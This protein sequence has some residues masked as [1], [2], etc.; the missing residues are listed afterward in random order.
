MKMDKIGLIQIDGIMPNLALMKASSFYKEKGFDVHFIDL[1]TLNI[2]NWLASKVF[3]GGSGY[4]LKENLPNEI[5]EITPDYEG[6]NLDY[7]IGFTSRGCFRNCDFCIVREKEGMIKE[8]SMDWIKHTKAIIMDNNF[9]G[10]PKWKEKLNYFIDNNIKVNFNQGLDIRLINKEN[11]EMLLKVKSY[12]RLFNKRAYYFAF[13]N[14]KDK[15]VILEKIQLLLNVGFKPHWLMFYI[16]CGHNSTH[17][18]DKERF[19]IIKDL[20][21]IP[22]IMKMNDRKDDVWLNNFDRWVNR[23]YYEFVKYEDYKDGFLE[24]K[25]KR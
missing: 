11:A 8:V 19:E 25:Q 4:N 23:K 5:E 14:I 17:Q 9:L 7:S 16:L 2:N 6:F 20:G 1:S 12:T 24:N 21:C 18:E 22:Y 15:K 10:S 13:D 3:V